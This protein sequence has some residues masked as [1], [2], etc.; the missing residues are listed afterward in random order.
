MS[1]LPPKADIAEL[2]WH[3]RFDQAVRLVP[4]PMIKMGSVIT[5]FGKQMALLWYRVVE[6]V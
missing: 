4:E 5:S 2:V 6:S 3:V 1:A